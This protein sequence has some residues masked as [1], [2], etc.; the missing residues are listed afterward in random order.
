MVIE[1]PRQFG[2]RVESIIQNGVR[3]AVEQL[4]AKRERSRTIDAGPILELAY[5]WLN[6]PYQASEQGSTRE[7]VET[8]A[9]GCDSHSHVRGLSRT[10]QAASPVS[11]FEA[12]RLA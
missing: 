3:V 9:V 11:R 10:G 2:T 6:V 8:V 12:R 1:V 5:V 4:R 7:P